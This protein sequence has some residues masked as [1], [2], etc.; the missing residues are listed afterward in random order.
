MPLPTRVSQLHMH[1]AETFCPASPG[2]KTGTTGLID[3]TETNGP[4]Q[5]R[6]SCLALGHPQPI[7]AE[8][9]RAIH[10]SLRHSTGM[11]YDLGTRAALY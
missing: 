5:I 8:G 3:P 9:T 6:L 11:G 1:V 7:E 10:G 2:W 4:L